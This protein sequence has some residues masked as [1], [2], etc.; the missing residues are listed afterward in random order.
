LPHPGA[1]LD[2]A[3]RLN[4]LER[5]GRTVRERAAG[6]LR[7]AE[8]GA[9]LFVNLHPNDLLDPTLT[10]ATSPLGQVAH[11]VHRDQRGTRLSH[12]PRLRPVARLFAC[13]PRATLSP[14]QLVKRVV[15]VDH[16]CEPGTSERG[17]GVQ[18]KTLAEL[19]SGYA[20]ASIPTLTYSANA[21]WQKLNILA[22]NIMTSFQITTTATEKP[23]TAKRTGLFLLRT[24]A[25]LRFEWLNTA[26]RLLRPSGAPTL[27][28]VENEATRDAG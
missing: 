12:R 8:E 6:P 18:E 2:A 1:V 25:T 15:A 9:L 26:A 17:R 27:R 28:L 11:R 13:P 23:R 16:R 19:K 22:H 10:D 7:G 4:A 5:L 3:E 21:A 20:F 24:I 14:P